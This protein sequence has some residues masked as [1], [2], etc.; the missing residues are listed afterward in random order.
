MTSGF[1]P[2]G[3]GRLVRALAGQG[4]LSAVACVTTGVVEQA[5][6]RHGLSPTATAALGRLLTAAA[7][8]ASLLKGRERVLLQVVGDGPLRHV[9]AEGE[10]GGGVRGYVGNPHVDLPPTPAGKLDVA[11]AVGK[12]QLVVVRDLGLKEPYRGA[13]PLVSGEIAQDMAY[14]L[15]R[16][17]QTP[18][19]VALGVLVDTDGSVKAAGGWLV[20]VLP[21]AEESLLARWEQTLKAAP[22]VTEV[23][24]ASR[25]PS[26]VGLLRSALGGEPFRV[27]E[28]RV[29]RYRCPCRRWRLEAGLMALG[30]QE[31][32]QMASGPDG[33]ELVCHFCGRRY[34][35]SAARLRQL[36]RRA[37]EARVR[38]ATEGWLES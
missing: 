38:A 16:S 37:G 24:A 10:A 21:G 19:A 15:A 23:L 20:T 26:A 33:V 30:S 31:L 9:V 11:G 4:Y 34:R 1:R 14:Y 5:R 8:L 2:A 29:V 12:G 18:S 22:P 17:E 27:L 7:L 32:D 6:Q 28:R 35:V 36:S 13:V 3:R 25:R